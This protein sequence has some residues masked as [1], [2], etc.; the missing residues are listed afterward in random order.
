MQ[1]DRA[2]AR[3]FTEAQVIHEQTVQEHIQPEQT[4]QEQVEL[5]QTTQDQTVQEQP[6]QEQVVQETRRSG[7]VRK[8]NM[9]YDP[10]IWDLDRDEMEEGT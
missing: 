3:E 9:K 4:M 6:R 10:D 7:R 2:A 8:T 5:E 1:G